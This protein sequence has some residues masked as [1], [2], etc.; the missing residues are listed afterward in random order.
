[1]S[2][3]LFAPACVLL[4]VVTLAPAAPAQEDSTE[5][6]IVVRALSRDAK[7]I[8]DKVGGARV[9]IVDVATGDTL[10]SGITTGETGDTGKIMI[11]PRER[12][13]R[14][15][16]TPGAASY[17][18]T[19][20]VDGPTEVEIHAEGP[21]DYPQA[22]ASASKRMWLTTGQDLTGEGLVLEL[23]GFI[24][25]ILEPG[26]VADPGEIFVRARVRMLCSCPT[27]PGGL[28][29]VERV[30]VRLLRDGEIVTEAPL[31]FSGETSVYGGAIEIA[32]PGEYDLVVLA[33][34]P[35]SRNYGRASADLVVE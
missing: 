25:E 12:G 26:R 19:F 20:A 5:T 11:E 1:M 10:D 30:D 28:W 16:D 18:A 31:R 15:F 35:V 3:K 17:T 24:V 13:A 29:S 27:E 21:L 4:A 8:G 23:H 14:V 7:L 33:E 34:D 6:R 32:E 9:T 2:S 22:R